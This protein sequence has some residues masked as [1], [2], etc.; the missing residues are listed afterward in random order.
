MTQEPAREP[1]LEELIGSGE[2]KLN[3]KSAQEGTKRSLCLLLLREAHGVNRSRGLAPEL[4]VVQQRMGP[5]ALCL[6]CLQNDGDLGEQARRASARWR[7]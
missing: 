3:K 4:L 7:Q 6:R 1:G 2:A 5:T